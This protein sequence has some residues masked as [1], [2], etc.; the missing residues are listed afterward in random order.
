M[1]I[2]AVDELII[3]GLHVSNAATIP[4]TIAVCRLMSGLTHATNANATASGIRANATVI[5]DKMSSLICFFFLGNQ[6][7]SRFN[8]EDKNK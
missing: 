4:I 7:N 5:H 3:H 6:A 1:A 8:I 2:A